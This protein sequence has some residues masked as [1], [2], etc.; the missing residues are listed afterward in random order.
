[1]EYIVSVDVGKTNGVAIAF[2]ENGLLIK[3][4]LFTVQ[5]TNLTDLILKCDVCNAQIVVEDFVIRRTSVGSKGEAIKVIGVLEH[6]FSVSLQQPSEKQRIPNERLKSL[7]ANYSIEYPS[8]PHIKDA[9][10][11]MFIY[12]FKNNLLEVN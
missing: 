8:S 1:M 5:H 11:H 10:R 4:E 9:L 3:C 12:C 6:F 2:I 7:C